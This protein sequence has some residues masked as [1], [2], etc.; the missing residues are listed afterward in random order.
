M[1]HLNPEP[2]PLAVRLVLPGVLVW[3]FGALT[4]VPT[5]DF[6]FGRIQLMLPLIFVFHWTLFRPEA[7]HWLVVIILGLFMDLWT[8]PV[9]GLSSLMLLGFQNVVI[10]VRNDLSDLPFQWRWIAFAVL[11]GLYL[12]IFGVMTSTVF[13]IQGPSSDLT[14]R[15][16]VCVGTYPVAIYLFAILERRVLYPQRKG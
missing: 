3:L 7:V 5:P 1:K 14:G 16:L 4:L 10:S 9:V 6:I 13:N 8:E 2:A 15:W 12:L 11:S